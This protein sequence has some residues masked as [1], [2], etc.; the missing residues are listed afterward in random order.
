MRKTYLFGGILAAAVLA[1]GGY[2]VF[3]S[4]HG[5]EETVAVSRAEVIRAVY[6]TGVVEPVNWAKLAPQ[7]V[8]QLVAVLH[9]EGEAVTEGE[10][11]AVLDSGVEQQQLAEARSRLDFTRKEAARSRALLAVR[12]ISRREAEA[13]EHAVTQAEAQVRAL[14][15]AIADLTLTAPMDGV[16]LRRDAEPGETLSPGQAAFWVGQ[17]KPLRITGEVDEE[18]IGQVQTG[19]EALIKSDAF[20]GRVFEGKISEI[21]PK[22]DPVN[23]VFRVRVAL[24][25]DTELMIGMTTELNIVIERIENALVVPAES[26]SGG[27]VWRMQGGRA[28]ETPVKTGVRDG[29]RVQI[30]EGVDEGDVVLKSPPRKD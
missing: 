18:D 24:P 2:Y 13:G 21:T 17:P 26:E 19:Q 9:D 22:G 5:A 23:K 27:K 12:G 1:A 25:E 4:R 8:A 29:E 6:A 14:E 28:V 3:S 10:K 30:V 16:V 7:R 11:V 20:P 15:Q